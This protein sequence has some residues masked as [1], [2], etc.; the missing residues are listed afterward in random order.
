MGI[1]IRYMNYGRI[2]HSNKIEVKV[3]FISSSKTT[4]EKQLKIDEV[5]K[6]YNN[7]QY[8]ED[9]NYKIKLWG[10]L[11]Y[12]INI[13]NIFQGTLFNFNFEKDLITL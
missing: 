13:N 7:N 2:L 9:C 11:R 3:H 6:S 8:I 10:Y 1:K 12:N 4:K 5:I